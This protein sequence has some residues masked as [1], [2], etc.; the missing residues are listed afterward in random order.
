MSGRAVIP[1]SLLDTEIN[2]RHLGHSPI[3]SSSRMNSKIDDDASGPCDF[4]HLTM[5]LLQNLT[6]EVSTP[7]VDPQHGR[8]AIRL[9]DVGSQK[10]MQH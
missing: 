2:L 5:H 1:A 4:K 3:N 6:V 10:Q 7:V 8:T 9:Q